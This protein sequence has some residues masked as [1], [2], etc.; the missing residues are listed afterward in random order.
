MK[1][2]LFQQVG[3]CFGYLSPNH[4]VT[5]LICCNVPAKREEGD[6]KLVNMAVLQKCTCYMSHN[7]AT[8]N[9]NITSVC[10]FT[11]KP[12][13]GQFN[14]GPHKLICSTCE[15]WRVGPAAAPPQQRPSAAAEKAL[16]GSWGGHCR[17]LAPQV[18]KTW[19]RRS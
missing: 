5:V 12:Q 3:S 15:W 7:G 2:F 11:R 13:K 9:V 8:L 6:C 19:D 4:G 17:S 1:L 14:Y 16:C 10:L 18:T